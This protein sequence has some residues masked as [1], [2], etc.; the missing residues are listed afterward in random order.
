MW[1]DEVDTVLAAGQGH[2]LT[3]AS[4]PDIRSMRDECR[5]V[6]DK[7]SY[8][9]RLVQGRLDIIAA[10]LRRRAE[11]GTPGDLP[12]LVE[13]LPEILSDRVRGPGAGR[14][15]SSTLPPEDDEDLV[16]ELDSIVAP[17]TLDSLPSLP[18]EDAQKLADDLRDL[19]RRVSERRRD[20]FA[21]IDA[22]QA[23]LAR[24]YKSGEA[25]VGVVLDTP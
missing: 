18:D 20:L 9:R 17:G 13:Q 23:E 8:L 21:R 14:L 3:A 11:G 25:S 24:R 16:A 2:D 1:S 6:E 5:R 10:E 4:L 19:E 7:I 12:S 22:L 15:P